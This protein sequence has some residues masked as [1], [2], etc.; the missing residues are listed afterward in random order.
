MR[1]HGRPARRDPAADEPVAREP[2]RLRS[3]VGHPRRARPAV[4]GRPARLRRLRAPRRSALAAGD[5]RVPGPA[6]RGGRPGPAAHR[7]ARRRYPGCAVRGSNAPGAVCQRDR[8]HRR[9]RVSARARRAAPFA[10]PRPRPRQVPPDRPARDHQRRRR[11]DRRRN[12]RRDPRGLPRLLRG[13]PLR[14]V[15]ALRTQLPRGAA[16]ACRAA[17]EITTPGHDHQRRP[18]PRR[19]LANAEFLDER[20]PN[21]RLRVLDA[22][23]FVWEEEPAQYAGSSSPRS[24]RAAHDRH[25]AR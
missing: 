11:H 10:G 2:V 17:A 23:H 3:H 14:R 20:L 25:R 5:G 16:R 7:R 15:D 8:R 24:P 22:G 13:R 18:R 21:S 1:R 19:P 9:S 12:P 4:R 6:R